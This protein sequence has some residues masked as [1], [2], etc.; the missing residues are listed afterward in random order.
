MLQPFAGVVIS[1]H[2]DKAKEL[3]AYQALMIYE[4]R[5]NSGKSRALY[6]SFFRQQIISL[7]DTDF[8]KMN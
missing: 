8:G 4:A 2:P 3:Y 7:S 1:R 6:D 5:C